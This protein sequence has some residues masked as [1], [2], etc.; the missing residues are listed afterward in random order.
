VA[1]GYV[2]AKEFESSRK[3]GHQIEKAR[4]RLGHGAGFESNLPKKAN[5]LPKG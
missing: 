3:V 1:A 5:A 2:S 4:K